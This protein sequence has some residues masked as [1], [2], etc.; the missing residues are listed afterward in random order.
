M[1]FQ[2]IKI[3]FL[4][5]CYRKGLSANSSRAYRQDLDDY[6]KWLKTERI[7]D[8]L[9]KEAITGW[10][11][12]LLDRELAPATV[13]R[14]L[15]CLKVLY[16][17]LEEVHGYE[18]D[19]F[20]H[21]RFS[22]RLPRRLPKNLSANEL[23]RLLNAPWGKRLPE[24]T[25]GFPKTTLRI[26]LEIM[27]TTGIRVGELCSLGL[28]DVDLTSRTLNI[29]GKGNRERRVFLVDRDIIELVEQY[30][31]LRWRLKPVTGNFLVTSCATPA[32]PDYIRR[33]LH[34]LAGDVGI[35]KRITPHML[36]H[37]AATQLLTGR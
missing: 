23:H 3:E 11:D 35:A 10:L 28:P 21:L 34:K 8:F 18:Q 14:R 25:A 37:S 26:A 36:R 30:L 7:S 24:T 22:I 27:F 5:Y 2:K 16:R 31:A 29:K 20:R 9:S 32:S 1:D 13:K 4:N 19:P 12:K 33:H 6:G 17:W 15:A